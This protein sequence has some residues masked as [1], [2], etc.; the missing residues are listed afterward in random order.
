LP[1][2]EPAGSRSPGGAAGAA[3]AL[4][5][6]PA[7]SPAFLPLL[8]A[9]AGLI[10]GLA[11]DRWRTGFERADAGERSAMVLGLAALL[12]LLLYPSVVHYSEQR[13]RRQIESNYAPF[14][15]DQPA[16][17]AEALAQSRAAVDGLRLL[18]SE[19]D[20]SLPAAE[21]LAF[22]VW[23]ASKLA[24]TAASSAVEIQDSRG[25]VISRFA[26]SLPSLAAT[27]PPQPLPPGEDWITTRET[28]TVATAERRVLHSSRRLAYDGQTRGAVHLYVGE[29]VAALPFLTPRDPY[30]AL[31]RSTS[32]PANGA[33]ALSLLVYDE[34]FNPVFTSAERPP[35]LSPEMSATLSRHPR[36][37]DH[38]ALE[39]AR[40]TPSFSATAPGATS[41]TRGS[42]PAGTARPPRAIV[43]LTWPSSS[44]SSP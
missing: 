1:R 21:D 43:A 22:A 16:R 3:A 34:S 12:A 26:L 44:R 32:G 36:G 6:R 15:L 2:A 30:S 20:T 19:T 11:L 42:P 39:S 24:E 29:G 10:L 35:A 8:L 40:P 9:S 23:S 17:R 37:P 33:K 41:G 13:T 14:I 7:K 27:G 38:S 5:F 18:E 28:L 4:T 25:T 31:Y